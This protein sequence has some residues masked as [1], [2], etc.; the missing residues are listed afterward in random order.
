VLADGVSYVWRELKV[1]FLAIDETG[2]SVVVLVEAVA[3]AVEVEPLAATK[4]RVVPHVLVV[5]D[6]D[7]AIPGRWFWL[8]LP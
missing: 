3:G 2:I 7:G 5:D 1:R 8:M 4:L 6:V